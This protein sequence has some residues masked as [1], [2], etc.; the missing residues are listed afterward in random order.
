MKK[1]VLIIVLLCACHLAGALSITDMKGRKIS[2]PDHISKVI[3]YDVK[4]SIVL[5]PCAG[6]KMIA[7]SILPGTKSIQYIAPRYMKIPEIDI[8]NAEEVLTVMP[9]VIIAGYY[10]SGENTER[11]QKLQEYLKIPVVLIDLSLGNLDKT[12]A[13][14]GSLLE[15]KAE[16]AV[17]SDYLSDVYKRIE[18]LRNSKPLPD[19]SVY[20]TLGLGGLMTDPSGSI[21]TEV[22]DFLDVPNA[23]KIGIPSGGHAKVNMEQV[24]IWNPDYIFAAG[25]KAESNAYKT[26][27]KEKSWSGIRAVKEGN[28]YKVPCQPFGWMDHPPSVNRIPG[29][30][31]LS[32]IFYDMP[33]KEE[34]GRI[35]QFYKLF[36]GYDLKDEEYYSLMEDL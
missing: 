19:H 27:L 1:T 16:C 11:Y 28:V 17:L 35:Q 23:A 22:F 13:F 18:A 4:T 29:V 34:K 30:I 20:Y 3:P 21:H 31:W 36:Y 25:F 32:R 24:M 33:Q 8:K 14:L 26:I 7:R 15:R 5:F 2:V 6:E 10:H 12:Y 9:D